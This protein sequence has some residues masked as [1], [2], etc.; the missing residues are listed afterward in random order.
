[1]IRAS[2]LPRQRPPT[3]ILDRAARNALTENRDFPLRYRPG[4][5]TFREQPLENATA[6][7]L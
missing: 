2:A 1:M 4:F 5:V 3:G 6:P 7:T